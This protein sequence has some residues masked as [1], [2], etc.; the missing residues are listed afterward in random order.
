MVDFAYHN[1]QPLLATLKI[2]TSRCPISSGS[3]Y[4][5]KISMLLN[6]TMEGEIIAIVSDCK[7]IAAIRTPQNLC[8]ALANLN[9]PH[10]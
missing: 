4:T 2:A 8:K 9:L 6:F 7:L 3:Q 1:R 10:F 5:F